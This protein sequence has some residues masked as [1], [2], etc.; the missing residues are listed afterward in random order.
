MPQD[1]LH[2]GKG[3]TIASGQ[4]GECMAQG[5]NVFD[6]NSSAMAGSTSGVSVVTLVG[7]SIS[8]ESSLSSVVG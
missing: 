7:L 5:V 3:D 2:N 4:V 6:T 1:R 8:V